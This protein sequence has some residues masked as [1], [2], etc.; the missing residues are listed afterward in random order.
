MQNPCKSHENMLIFGI[1]F[2]KKLQSNFLHFHTGY[3]EWSQEYTSKLP[4]YQNND[5]KIGKIQYLSMRNQIKKILIILF[6]EPFVKS[7]ALD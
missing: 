1:F 2:L 3:V 5:V 6:A 4:S 7:S